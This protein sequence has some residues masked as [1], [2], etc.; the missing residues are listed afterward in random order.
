MYSIYVCYSWP[1]SW[2]KL[3]EI[4]LGSLLV[5]GTLGVQHRQKKLKIAIPWATPG[6]ESSTW[7]FLFS[8]FFLTPSDFFISAW[9]GL[10]EVVCT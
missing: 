10:I 9:G 4:F 6:K 1:N 7:A 8:C 5:V 2:T 3:A